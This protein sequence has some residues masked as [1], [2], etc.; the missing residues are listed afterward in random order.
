MKNIKGMSREELYA[1][2]VTE[3]EA[4]TTADHTPSRFEMLGVLC[5]D[6]GHI[7]NRD[8]TD[9]IDKLYADGFVKE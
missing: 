8:A 7:I 2:L 4:R 1:A 3:A 5:D 6:W 9:L